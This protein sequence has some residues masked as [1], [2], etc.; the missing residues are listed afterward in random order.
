VDPQDGAASFYELS[1]ALLVSRSIWR[2]FTEHLYLNKSLFAR[3]WIAFVAHDGVRCEQ[4]NDSS[5]DVK[6]R[7]S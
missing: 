4:C 6:D 5:G 7:N 1:V 2:H 3:V